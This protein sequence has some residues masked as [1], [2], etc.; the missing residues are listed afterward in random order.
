[1]NP[2]MILSAVTL[3]LQNLPQLIAAGK[4]VTSLI[5]NVVRTFQ[6]KTSITKE[7]LDAMVA[8]SKQLE[9]EIMAPLPDGE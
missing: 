1:M 8:R 9:D 7:E 4:D 6:G 5:T 2:A 3:A